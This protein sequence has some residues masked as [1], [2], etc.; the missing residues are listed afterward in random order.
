MVNK[1]EKVL[2]VKKMVDLMIDN[3]VL[4]VKI[5]E[6]EREYIQ[7]KGNIP[8][9]GYAILKMRKAV[10]SRLKKEIDD[11]Q[12]RHVE[13]TNKIFADPIQSIPLY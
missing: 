5:L 2:K 1:T 12:L 3:G 13:V 9:E 10:S 11:L 4:K 6:C 7:K 8:I